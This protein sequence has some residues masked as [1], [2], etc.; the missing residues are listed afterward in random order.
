MWGR[1]KEIRKKV[2]GGFEQVTEEGNPDCLEKH[3]GEF[4]RWTKSCMEIGDSFRTNFLNVLIWKRT[5]DIQD[6][7]I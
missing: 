3:D 1:K 6:T 4:T 2:R 7:L 5:A